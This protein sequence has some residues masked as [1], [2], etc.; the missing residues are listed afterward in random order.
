[1]S[2]TTTTHEG[3]RVCGRTDVSLKAD[4]TL[5]MHVRADRKGSS[6]LFPDGNRCRGAGHPPKGVLGRYA[7]ATIEVLRTEFLDLEK[8]HIA[9]VIGEAV[10]QHRA[11]PSNSLEC[12]LDE[13]GNWRLKSAGR[14]TGRVRLA[15]FLY[16]ET[17][18]EREMVEHLNALLDNLR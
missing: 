11:V 12:L 7:K 9:D 17:R 13:R 6:F 3:C 18:G 5:R 16:R 8:Q 4:G 2:D 14:D 1:M 10:Q 15:C